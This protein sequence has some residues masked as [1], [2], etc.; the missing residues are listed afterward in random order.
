MSSEVLESDSKSDIRPAPRPSAAPSRRRRRS[1]ILIPVAAG[2][3]ALGW[4][5]WASPL[6]LV[7]HVVVQSAPGVPEESVRLASGI[8][9]TDHV[10]GVSE[11][12]V[13]AAIMGS[14]PAVSDVDIKRS[15][16]DTIRISLT[17]REPL[18]VISD[19]KQLRVI[20]SAGVAFDTIGK[21][22]NLPV[23]K[24]RT[25]VGS[26]HARRVLLSLPADLRSRVRR[27]SASTRDD[28]T[29]VLT[30]GAVVRWGNLADADL[31]ARV[32]DSLIII[33]ADRY[34]VSAPFQPTT[35]GG[36]TS[37]PQVVGEP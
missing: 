12:H 16:P 17:I 1:R 11:S 19:G 9:V 10:P 15:L 4:L 8:S 20:D 31:K 14:L 2:C 30:G 3:A 29:L 5:G 18:G 36:N 37:Q 27:I 33:G 32:L 26:E 28:V 7:K 23:I 35:Q 13:R 25:K 6:T 22:G 21:A 34:D 24:S